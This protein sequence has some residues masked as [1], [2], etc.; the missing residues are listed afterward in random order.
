MTIAQ[1]ESRMLR[2][3]YHLSPRHVRRIEALRAELGLDSDAALIRRAIDTFD[4]DALDASERELVEDTA[5]DLLERIEDLNADIERTLERTQAAR[6]QLN[7][8]AWIESIR[9][10]TRREAE[11]DPALVAGVAQMI[12]A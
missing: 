5:K 9:E 3:Q 1:D 6:K 8:P 11:N 12:G 10:R 2:K 7:D 4:P